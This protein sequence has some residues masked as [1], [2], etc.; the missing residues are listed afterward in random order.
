M[1]KSLLVLVVMAVTFTCV[2]CNNSES[3]ISTISGTPEVTSLPQEDNDSDSNNTRDLES[4]T[5]EQ[6]R[7]SDVSSVKEKSRAE[8]SDTS[9][10]ETDLQEASRLLEELKAERSKLM[11]ESR[12]LEEAKKEQSKLLEESRLR[13]QSRLEYSRLLEESRLQEES[14]LK[15]QSRLL[16]ESKALEE[17][18]LKQESLQNEVYGAQNSIKITNCSV[19][20][21][22]SAGGVDVYI[23]FYNK[24]GKTIKYV[25]Y[26]VQ[27]YN[28][29]DDP[30]NCEIRGTSISQRLQFTGP[31]DSGCYSN[32]QL[33]YEQAK[34]RWENRPTNYDELEMPMELP[35]ALI[36]TCWECVWYN[37][38]IKYC[39]L[40]DVSIE[41]MDGTSTHISKEN[42]SYLY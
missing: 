36:N 38:S 31:V 10:E 18:R 5:V 3:L 30:A 7:V 1:R 26:Q 33:E 22:N 6:S 4:F 28:A 19:S 16:E 39:K 12:L 35:T 15:E 8:Q 14:R 42:I 20:S 40:I 41:Y 34:E 2:G 13:E 25:Y 11:E 29:V 27:A 23:D 32:N 24:S 9:S 21:P 17:S 37:Y